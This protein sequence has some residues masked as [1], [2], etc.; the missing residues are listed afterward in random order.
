MPV[1]VWD[2]QAPVVQVQSLQEDWEKPVISVSVRN[3]HQTPVPIKALI[4][5]AW[6][7]NPPSQLKKELDVAPGATEILALNARDGGPEGLHTTRILLT[8]PDEQKTYYS[9][10]FRWSLHRP[11]SRWSI[12]QEQ[13]RAV[14]LQF[15]YYPYDRKARIRVGIGTLSLKDKVT[16]AVAK[17]RPV[18]KGAKA[19]Q[20]TL[21]EQRLS[22]TKYLSERVYDIPDL[23][24]GKYELA[25]TL[26]GGEGLPGE[27]VIQPFVRKRF[28]WER[29]QLGISDEVMPPFTPLAAR[30]NVVKSVLREH[31]HG[32]TG[33]WRSLKSQERELLTT[34]MSW[35]V[36]ASDPGG[37]PKTLKVRGKGWRL[38]ERKDTEVAGEAEWTAGP[39][40]AQVRT[41]Y[42]YDG[43]M[44][45][46]LTLEPTGEGAL[47]R[48]S[49]DIPIRESEARYMHAVGDGL[50][51]NYAGFVPKGEGKAWGS[52]RA[53]KIN[54][55]GA[56]FPYLWVGGGE[57]GVCWF[58]DTDRDLR[59][60]D[61]TPM[62]E[63]V[64]EG[65]TLRMRVHLITRPGPL[66]RKHR[67]V[68]GLQATPTKPMP[69]GWRKWLALKS[70]P[71]C[72]PVRWWGATYYWGG[73]SYDV[74]PYRQKYDL[75]EAFKKR[76]ETGEGGDA[77]IAKWMKD[78]EELYPK[79][80][81]RYQFLFSHIRAGFHNARCSPWDKGWRTFGYTNARGIGFHAPAFATFQDEWLRYPYFNREWSEHGAIAYDVSPSRSFQ[82]FVLW[83]Y[84]K[85]MICFDGV[86]WDNTFLSA[87]YDPVVGSAWTDEKGRTH[88]GLGLFH[89]RDLIKRTAIMFWQESKDLPDSRKPFLTLSHMTNTMIVPVLSFGNCNMDW[90]WKYGYEDFQDRFSADLTVAETLARQVGAW[91][92]ILAGGHPNPKD[93]RTPWMWRTRLGVCLVHEIQ[94]FSWRPPEES[95]MYRKLYE[96]GYGDD[97][98]RVFNY[99]DEGHPVQVE[100]KTVDAHTLALVKGN[101]ALAVVTDYGEGG[102]CE[103]KLD[104]K[105]LGLTREV[106]ASD[107]ETSKEIERVEPGVFRF[108]LKKHDFRILRIE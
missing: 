12:G 79:D 42:D 34:P 18:A 101:R 28:E 80:S 19:R 93:P 81:K 2:P 4:E 54:I 88:P 108:T 69:E 106:N 72:R 5:D 33:L 104:L 58:A 31:E 102:E 86:Y 27:P 97:D 51:H 60:D 59:L 24:D 3:P 67:I 21:W 44:L 13:R 65:R 68:F 17:I 83:Y 38:L 26:E 55:V 23:A 37:K 41:V 7:H 1:M 29:N 76:R 49:L 9:R 32:A 98:C 6:H 50:R 36:T 53:N 66:E 15:K 47:H 103:V 77:H 22:F 107:F 85:M 82:D 35:H 74:Y 64:R 96:F 99:W 40:K 43:M 57:R 52:G 30:R 70:A 63:L 48:L 16:G 89:L 92:T 94:S 25:V 78:V 87:H 39:L 10:R 11:E 8:S 20:A 45:V 100:S 73:I 56:F 46:T 75:F 90:E 91:P 62:M 95:A 61:E 84:R 71:G 105:G 14:D